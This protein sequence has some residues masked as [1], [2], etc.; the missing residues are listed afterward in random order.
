MQ[1]DQ[2]SVPVITHTPKQLY[3]HIFRNF[4]KLRSILY[5]LLATL[6]ESETFSKE[7]L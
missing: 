6:T 5:F 4:Q 2:Q 7:L 3:Y 1:I